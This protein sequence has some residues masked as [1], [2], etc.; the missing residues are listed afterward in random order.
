MAVLAASFQAA[1]AGSATELS[2]PSTQAP[3]E[4]TP[5]QP[6][7]DVIWLPTPEALVERM[8]AMAQVGPG[9]LVYDLGSG[10]GR[11][12][13][14][15]AKR[16]ARAVGIEYNPE[17]VAF[18]EGRARARGV[19]EKARFVHGDI[20]ATDFSEATVVTLYL[21]QALNL[22]LRPTLLKMRPGTR[23]VSHGFTMGD[24]EPDEVSRAEQR[25]AY[26]WIV[27]A[28]VEGAWRV[29]LSGGPS[30]DLALVQRYQKIE[31]TIALGA[32]DAGLREASL[33]GDAIR[34]A[35]VDGDG[36]RH[37]LGGVVS[38]DRMTGSFEAGGRKGEWTA[39][40]R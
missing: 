25:A 8:L 26:L 39:T 13:L 7:K 18:S 2:P 34:F 12:V 3:D 37:G 21:L 4:P 15:A 29:E 24:W 28:A 35:Y 6:G 1:P 40:R 5:G 38:G 19:A 31:G 27:P 20:F 11:T 32:V 17:L 14:A 10:D 16:G 33:R 22:R 30:F 36:V 9:D 23:V